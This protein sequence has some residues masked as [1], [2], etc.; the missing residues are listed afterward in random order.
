M[1]GLFLVDFLQESSFSHHLALMSSCCQAN[2]SLMTFRLTISIFSV[3]HTHCH[4]MKRSLVS[5]PYVID[6]FWSVISTENIPEKWTPEVKHF[7][8][9]VPIILVGNKKD[10]RND[11]HT[12]RELAKMKQVPEIVSSPKRCSYNQN[13]CLF[14]LISVLR[15]SKLSIVL[16][17][18]FGFIWSVNFLLPW[19]Q[20][21]VNLAKLVDHMQNIPSS[22]VAIEL[23]KLVSQ[24][25]NMIH[26]QIWLIW[27][28]GFLSPYRSLWNQ[29]KAGTWPIESQPSVTWN[30]L[31]RPRTVFGRCLRWPPGRPCRPVAA[32]RAANV[33]C[34]KKAG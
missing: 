13:K 20:Q 14:W 16:G 7:C 12:R 1:E 18:V 8:P 4:Y 24:L 2:S 3:V 22:I 21:T 17:T 32:R 5:Y 29:M 15:F 31:P 6:L 10:L 30:A 11:E 23:F 28:C 34:C 33:Y 27:K 9:N 19:Q 25:T 26:T